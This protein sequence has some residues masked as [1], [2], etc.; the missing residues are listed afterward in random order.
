MS[1]R[2]KRLVRIL[3]WLLGSVVLTAV[4]AELLAQVV[5]GNARFRDLLQ[6]DPGDGRCVALRPNQRVPYTGWFFRIPAVEHEVNAL[7]FRGRPV[8]L[9][10]SAATRIAVLGDSF[11][12][13]VGVGVDDTI[14]AQLER[15]IAAETGREVE[16]LNFGVPGLNVE[17]VA[18]QFEPF[19]SRWS[20]DTVLYLV[21]AND[22][23]HG[24]C[25][26]AAGLLAA[27][28][29]RARIVRTSRF[30][31]LVYFVWFLP[32]EMGDEAKRL[33]SDPGAVDRFMD[34]VSRLAS[35]AHEKHASLGL[36]NLGWPVLGPLRD[37]LAR[38]L[39]GAEIPLLDVSIIASHPR[40]QIHMEGHLNPEGCRSV[41]EAVAQWLQ[42]DDTF[43]SLLLRE[44]RAD[45]GGA[46]A[47]RAPDPGARSYGGDAPDRRRTHGAASAAP[48]PSSVTPDT[49]APSRTLP[50]A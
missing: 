43:R 30:A 6:F 29:W 9:R 37:E 45:G 35:V 15:A 12:F 18:E 10:R 20:P 26:G 42:K 7:G 24:I 28:G 31:R 25:G 4:L 11:T 41:A 27:D 33:A 17:E 36:V 50:G 23:D 13:G 46:G 5:L 47:D 3:R 8:P 16:V 39:A 32:K 22:L 21:F 19:A 14:P 48:I 2:S 38:R 34:A 44:G 40:N 49:N 1:A